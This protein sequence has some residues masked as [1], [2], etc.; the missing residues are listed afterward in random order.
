M[1]PPACSMNEFRSW[2]CPQVGCL[3][4]YWRVLG[5]GICLAR[6]KHRTLIPPKQPS[7]SVDIKTDD[8]AARTRR[9]DSLNLDITERTENMG[10][11]EVYSAV[12][13]VSVQELQG[14]APEIELTCLLHLLLFHHVLCDQV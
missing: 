5:D 4:F 6:A 12:N 13:T 11:Q 2:F 8:V 10:F 7:C 14:S 9:V 1:V 3:E